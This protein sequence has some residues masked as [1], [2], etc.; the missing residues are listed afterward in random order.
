MNLGR[1]A[2]TGVLV[3]GLTAAAEAQQ[4]AVNVERLPINLQRIQ[5]Q[6]R[7]STIRETRNGLNIRY[8]VDVYGQAPQI[9]FFTR[10]GDLPTGPVPYGGP[11][12]QD[13]LQVI[14]PQEHRAPVMDFNALLRWL[15]DKAKK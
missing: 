6:L 7:Q 14:T 13:V 8:F 1:I 2:F 3:L 9:E 11:T 4:S 15:S 12:H 10:E 5:R